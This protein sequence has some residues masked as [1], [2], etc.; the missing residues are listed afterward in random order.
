MLKE[1]DALVAQDPTL[2]V[3]IDETELRPT[4]F[5]PGDIG[6]FADV[7]GHAAALRSTRLAIF[8]TNPAMYG[9]NRMFQSMAD[10]HGRMEAFRDLSSALAWLQEA[11]DTTVG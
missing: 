2:R 5:T 9:L 7:W 6:R 1:L 8:V 10:A 3:L 11:G 4:L